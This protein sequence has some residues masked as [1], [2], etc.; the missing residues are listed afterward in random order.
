[1]AK[2]KKNSASGMTFVSVYMPDELYERLAAYAAR[3]RRSLS[4]MV[5][6]FIEEK[7]SVES[8]P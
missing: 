3:E 6:L 1:M 7:L 8:K 4:Q 5:M 2:P